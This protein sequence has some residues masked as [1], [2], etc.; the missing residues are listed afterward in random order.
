MAAI[1]GRLPSGTS[2]VDHDLGENSNN[3][4]GSSSLNSSL[5]NFQNSQ[6]HGK[7]FTSYLN[8]R[9]E[10]PNDISSEL[11]V[12]LMK[13]EEDEAFER[14]RW[15][16]RALLFT[17]FFFLNTVQTGLTG[18]LYYFWEQEALNKGLKKSEIFI[19]TLGLSIG[20]FVGL[21][22][23]RF[24]LKFLSRKN[25]WLLQ[26]AIYSFG[27]F[28]FAILSLFSKETIANPDYHSLFLTASWFSLV[29]VGIGLF[30]L[31]IL[32]LSIISKLFP[33]NLAFIVQFL[34]LGRSIGTISAP[35]I[36]LF[37][38]KFMSLPF[39]FIILT[40][41][42][43]IPFVTGCLLLPRTKPQPK[44]TKLGISSRMLLSNWRGVSNVLDLV[45]CT[46]CY[47]FLTSEV[48]LFLNEKF[49]LTT[50]ERTI[51][52]DVMMMGEAV[53]NILN[54]C[55]LSFMDHRISH[56]LISMLI[57][58][59]GMNLAGG[60]FGRLSPNLATTVIGFGLSQLVI[61]CFGTVA[62]DLTAL[63]EEITQKE[64]SFATRD[65]VSIMAA[66]FFALSSFLGEGLLT[67][68]FKFSKDFE[69]LICISG[70]FLFLFLLNYLFASKMLKER[71]FLRRHKANA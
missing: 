52:T 8:K 10:T 26:V 49:D 18:L 30:S 70:F 62:H 67:F 54:I 37:L 38:L 40:S 5:W 2:G 39:I 65:T 68:F 27:F 32:S 6:N 35:I 71:A 21:F 60:A 19:I 34:S 31:K 24:L 11:L 44:S 7:Q 22:S 61:S 59:I 17:C 28:S 25:A 55:I 33:K 48:A 12:A 45:L 51:C 23:V 20:F 66:F 57:P 3:L 9:I 15:F 58:V 53:G 4:F 56:I 69:T 50:K 46:I 64:A 63:A 42:L 47:R 29:V 1:E 36:A 43:S 41:L 14:I 16:T 13:Y